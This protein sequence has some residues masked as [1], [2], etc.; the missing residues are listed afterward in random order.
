MELCLNQLRN[1]SPFIHVFRYVPSL[2]IKFKKRVVPYRDFQA[3]YE[4]GGGLSG[5]TFG[6]LAGVWRPLL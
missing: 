3:A 4:P 5:A 6:P 2:I 1:L